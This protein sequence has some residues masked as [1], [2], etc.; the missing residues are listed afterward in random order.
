VLLDNISQMNADTE[1]DAALGRQA[2][3]TFDHG[4]LHFDC[5][6][7]C[8]NHAT[9]LNENPITSA[10]HHSPIMHSDGGVDQVAPE[11]A[12]PR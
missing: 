9:E 6:A 4:V 3:V 8:L 7:H 1:L 5:A 2:G 12:Q 10:L 11:S